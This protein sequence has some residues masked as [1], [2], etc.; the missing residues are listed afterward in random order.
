[1]KYIVCFFS[2]L[3]FIS[4]SHGVSFQIHNNTKSKIDSVKISGGSNIMF[5]E[6]KPYKTVNKFMDFK[7]SRSMTDGAFKIEIF[8][9]DQVRQQYFGYIS[10]GIPQNSGFLLEISK[11][12]VKIKTQ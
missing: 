10:N 3:L 12:T 4:C 8:K 9:K 5:Y 7:N 6:I 1:M 2:V 11:D